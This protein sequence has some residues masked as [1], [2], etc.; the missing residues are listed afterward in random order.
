[1]Q[2]IERYSKK[3]TKKDEIIFENLRFICKKIQF[4]REF[5]LQ[6]KLNRKNVVLVSFTLGS[7]LSTYENRDCNI[8]IE[9]KG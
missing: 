1:M 2:S 4:W 3:L 9:Y 6:L 8:S 5:Y 7:R